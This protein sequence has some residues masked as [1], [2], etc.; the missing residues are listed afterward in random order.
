MYSRELLL[1]TTSVHYARMSD[2]SDEL[3]A[4]LLQ[5]HG[6]MN[7]PDIDQ[8]FLARAGVKLDRALFPLLSRIGRS[9]PIGVVELASLVGRG[10]STVSRQVAK[11]EAL[12]LV[13]RQA[14]KGDQRV[15]LLEPSAAGWKML[16]QF[17]RARRRFLSNRLDGWTDEERSMLL[18]LLK[19]LSATVAAET[20]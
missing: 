18:D 3:H 1:A 7:R 13:E 8:A 16:D 20:P 12:G 2:W 19:R 14:A 10:H 11:L 15:R 5:L 4:V 6:Y 17:A 9:R